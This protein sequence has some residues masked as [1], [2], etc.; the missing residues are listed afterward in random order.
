[1]RLGAAM[2]LIQTRRQHPEP[3]ADLLGEVF[4]LA[5]LVRSSLKVKGKLVVRAQGDGLSP[6][7]WPTTRQPPRRIAPR[8][9]AGAS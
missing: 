9:V 4:A 1:M 6:T 3:A 8:R 7:W 2:G 5:A